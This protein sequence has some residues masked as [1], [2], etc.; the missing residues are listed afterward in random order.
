LSNLV[1]GQEYE[2][3]IKAI[4]HQSNPLIESAFASGT[5]FTTSGTCTTPTSTQA[6][7][8]GST[9]A[10]SW[11]GIVG[12]DF[13][14]VRF[15]PATANTWS[16]ATTTSASLTLT[17]NPCT[18]YVWNVRTVCRRA[19]PEV[20]SSFI[21]NDIPITTGGCN[22]GRQDELAAGF[23]VYPN[24]SEGEITLKLNSAHTNTPIKV[25]I[26]NSLGK[27]VYS[28]ENEGSLEQN[29]T[30]QQKGVYFARVTSNGGVVT[31]QFIIQ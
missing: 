18:S 19:N 14:V 24:P 23:N 1:I 7:I 25:Q 3:A 29:I 15:K 20:A 31:K 26:F 13:Y 11:R 9:V 22:S 6:N 27:E 28:I 30:L 8:S 21:A 4:C 5:N 2:W 16:Y 12:A 10:L 17:L